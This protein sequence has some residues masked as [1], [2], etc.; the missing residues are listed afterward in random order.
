MVT[1]SFG[2]SWK[3]SGTLNNLTSLS[4]FHKGAPIKKVHGIAAM[5]SRRNVNHRFCWSNLDASLE[6]IIL[7][8]KYASMTKTVVIH[9]SRMKLNRL[10]STDRTK[11]LGIKMAEVVQDTTTINCHNGC[12]TMP[13]GVI[14]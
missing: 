13:R 2:L 12:F 7:N 8:R 5:Q 11:P 10:R 14:I 9:Q 6:R 4:K 1:G 3:N